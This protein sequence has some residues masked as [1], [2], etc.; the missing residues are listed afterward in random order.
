MLLFVGA[1]IAG[2]LLLP[3]RIA[4]LAFAGWLAIVMPGIRPVNVRFQNV[5]RSHLESE[6][7]A[8]VH[9]YL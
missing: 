5:D 8:D 1:W 3:I 4:G 2:G 9:P 7:S 6:S